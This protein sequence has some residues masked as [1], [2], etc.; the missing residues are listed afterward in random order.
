MLE[1]FRAA[2]APAIKRL[3]ELEATEKLPMPYTGKRPPFSDALL[4]AGPVAVIAEYKR[5]SPS[6]GDINLGLSPAEVAAMYAASGAAAISVLTE[7][8]YFKGS[9]DYLET[10]GAV[11]LP[12]LRK[13]FLLHPL[14]V[15][16]TAAT[17]ASALLLIVR[18]LTDEELS[19]MLR[20]TYDAGLEAVVEVFDE[21]DLERAEKAG[22][23]IVQVNSRDLDTLKTDLDVARRMAA[24]KRP[25]RIWIAASGISSRADVLGMAALG[26]NAVLVGTSLM[27]G[28]D[29][30][31]ALAR[32]TGKA[33]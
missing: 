4:A 14:Q 13:D 18:M 20:L 17:K 5:A 33:D 31:L 12:M 1:K 16:E 22:A 9:L 28:E 29:P 10:I 3:K 26:Y 15:V 2:Q 11:G 30:G 19:E 23:R 21:A 32:L 25:G 7:E 8:T 27:S 6:A 24:K